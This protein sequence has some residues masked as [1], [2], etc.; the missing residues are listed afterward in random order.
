[1]TAYDLAPFSFCAL[2]RQSRTTPPN[3][4]LPAGKATELK[5]GATPCDLLAAGR[6]SGGSR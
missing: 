3:L 1:M 4:N 2:C 6:A 5:V